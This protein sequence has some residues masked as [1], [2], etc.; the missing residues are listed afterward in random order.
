MEQSS[1]PPHTLKSTPQ[2]FVDLIGCIRWASSWQ[3]AIKQQLATDSWM[4]FIHNQIKNVSICVHVR[5]CVGGGGGWGGVGVLAISL[6]CCQQNDNDLQHSNQD[7]FKN[8]YFFSTTSF[9]RISLPHHTSFHIRNLTI[10]SQLYRTCARIQHFIIYLFFEEGG[11]VRTCKDHLFYPRVSDTLRLQC[12]V[13]LW[14]AK[15]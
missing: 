4:L 5:V 13:N 7:F 6:N 11:G 8:T 1:P 2:Y 9:Y 14:L 12:I 15:I 10:D 3:Q